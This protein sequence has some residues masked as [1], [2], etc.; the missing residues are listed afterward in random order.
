MRAAA[1]ALFALAGCTQRTDLLAGNAAT[2]CAASGAPV[3]LVGD[4]PC[5]PVLAAQLYARALCVCD[6]LA[7][8]GALLTHAPV[9]TP[10]MPGP[11]VV[12][13]ALDGSLAVAGAV[14]LFGGLDVAG[15]GGAR[16]GSSAFVLGRLRAGGPVAT[17]QL[18]STADDLYAAGD[19]SGRIDV[20]GDVH[21]P[22][23]ALVPPTV[24]AR[25]L[26]RAPVSVA[27]ACACDAPAFDA[28][29]AVRAHA[30]RNDDGA[31]ALH[32]AAVA[33]VADGAR[34]DLPCGAYYVDA[35][36]GAALELHIHGKTALFVG[37]DVALDGALQ[38][39][40]DAGAE[41]DLVVAGDFAASAVTSATA[42]ATR[43]WIGGARVRLGS[44][45][46]AGLVHAPAATL[47]SAGALTTSGAVYVAGL[48]VGGDVDLRF[49]RR[50]LAAAAATCK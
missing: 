39:A 20:N 10:P 38:V 16:F 23:G 50:A 6:D 41:L 9:M 13:V 26:V 34:L 37:R 21:V 29:A 7:L 8:P 3:A 44:G 30:S 5:A 47:S 40:L 45:T 11:P 31:I 36:A 19:L 27:P 14:Q 43:L 18:L 12:D 32:P 17:A 2:R 46:L 15:A 24:S 35:I 25:G 22:P 33:H 49:D 1:V 42:T 48:A 28:A 4:V